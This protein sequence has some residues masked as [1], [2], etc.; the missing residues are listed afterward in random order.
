[1][2]IFDRF[3]RAREPENEAPTGQHVR[4]FHYAFAHWAMPWLTSKHPL[5]FLGIYEHEAG[6]ADSMVEQL[7]D[8]A[9]MVASK[10]TPTFG[11][12]QVG[13]TRTIVAGCRCLLFVLPPPTRQAEAFMVALLLT[14]P[15]EGKVTGPIVLRNFTLEYSEVHDP[16]HTVFCEWAQDKNQH[17]N[18]G[19]GPEPTPEAFLARI[20]A[21][22]AS[23]Q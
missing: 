8:Y 12:A 20:E 22:V 2:G 13:I 7:F 17:F 10:G 6:F 4:T 3:R 11:P 1:M 14:E 21:F 19:L 9:A 18:Y 16:P 23:G 15:R 5:F